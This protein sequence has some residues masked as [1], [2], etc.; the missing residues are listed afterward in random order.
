[1]GE[2]SQNHPFFDGNGGLRHVSAFLQV[3]GYKLEFDDIAVAL[4]EFYENRIPFR[5][6]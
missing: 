2:L 5:S 6:A 1:V 3:N 4:M